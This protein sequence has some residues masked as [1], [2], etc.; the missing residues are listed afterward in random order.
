MDAGEAGWDGAVGLVTSLM[1]GLT[2]ELSRMG[3]ADHQVLTTIMERH[4]KCGVDICRHCHMDNK[5]ACVDD[6][7]FSLAELRHLEI[8]E[9]DG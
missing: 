7:V 2:P 1:D 3:F 6:P 9:L 5:L 4:M 8:M